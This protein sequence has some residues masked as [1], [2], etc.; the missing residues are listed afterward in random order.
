MTRYLG[1]H[2]IRGGHGIGG[3]FKL[4]GFEKFVK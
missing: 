4:I 2:G 1:G 3:G